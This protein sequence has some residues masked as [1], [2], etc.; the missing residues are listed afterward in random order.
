MCLTI[1]LCSIITLRELLPAY[2]GSGK[3]A[4]G[5]WHSHLR[6]TKVLLMRFGS[7]PSGGSSWEGFIEDV[8]HSAQFAQCL[9]ELALA[10][11]AHEL[12]EKALVLVAPEQVGN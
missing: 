7:A 8:L 10:G 5:M 6:V 4:N 3:D 2:I 1:L 11:H 9:H 12:P